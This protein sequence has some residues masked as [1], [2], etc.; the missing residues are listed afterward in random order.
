MQ[1]EGT[2]DLFFIQQYKYLCNKVLAQ[3]Y[4][5]NGYRLTSVNEWQ[6]ESMKEL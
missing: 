4:G 3:A 6:Q 5:P 2:L 1:S